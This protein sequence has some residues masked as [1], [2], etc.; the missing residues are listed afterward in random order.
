MRAVSGVSREMPVHNLQEVH[1]VGEFAW[2][3]LASNLPAHECQIL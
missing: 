1:V 2:P 3:G